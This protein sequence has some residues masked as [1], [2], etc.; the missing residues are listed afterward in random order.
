MMGC[1]GKGGGSNSGRYW[2]LAI[3]SVVGSLKVFESQLKSESQ[4]LRLSVV[5]ESCCIVASHRDFEKTTRR[6]YNDYTATQKPCSLN[7]DVQVILQ[8]VTKD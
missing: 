3:E 6:L 8:H 5:N 4:R 7:V 1:I 2:I